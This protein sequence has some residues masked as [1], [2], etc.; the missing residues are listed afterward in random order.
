MPGI[1]LHAHV[2]LEVMELLAAPDLQMPHAQLFPAYT[3]PV[4]SLPLPVLRR[5]SLLLLEVLEWTGYLRM[6]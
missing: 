3:R 1:T 6:A 5:A 2:R 4:V